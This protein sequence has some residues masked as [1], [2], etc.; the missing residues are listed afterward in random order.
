MILLDT[1]LLGRITAS[2]DPQCAVSRRAIHRLSAAGE[3]LVIIPQNLYE[4]W[5]VAT[6]PRGRPP[7]GSNGLGLTSNQA[8]QWLTYFQRRFDFRPDH[9]DLHAYWHTLV[10]SLNIVGSKSHDAR[11]VAAMQVLGASRLLTFNAADFRRLPVTVIDPAT[12]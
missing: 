12:V 11:L 4:F 10:K 2:A 1:N 8:S 9:P 6:R 5:A 7:A 3:K